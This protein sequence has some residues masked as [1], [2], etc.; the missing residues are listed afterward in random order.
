MFVSLRSAGVFHTA[1]MNCHAYCHEFHQILRLRRVLSPVPVNRADA[2]LYL[3]R[4]VDTGAAMSEKL[5]QMLVK[6]GLTAERAEEYVALI[7]EMIEAG[8]ADKGLEFKRT[9]PVGG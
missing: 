7:E 8:I 2:A 3:W 5:V 9:G 6:D 4:Q 1:R